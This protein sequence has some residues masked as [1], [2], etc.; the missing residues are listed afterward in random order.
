M[1]RL[2]VR[3]VKL[4]TDNG[5]APAR[6]NAPA[7]L[8]TTRRVSC[9]PDSPQYRRG[10]ARN[11][12]GLAMWTAASVLAC[13]LSVLG[14]SESSMPRIELIDIAPPAVSAGAEAFVHQSTRT[15]Y[16]ITSSSVF[17]TALSARGCTTSVAMRKLA[18]ILAHEEWHVR[19]CP[20]EKSAYERQLITLIQL[21]LQPGSGVYREVQLSMLRVIEARKRNKPERLLASLTLF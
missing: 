17:Q 3:A 20:D 5:G 18:S 16:L 4:P 21:G 12:K 14:R 2:P 19:H 9:G 8:I 1:N 7:P 10:P 6:G 13:A 15:I 11:R